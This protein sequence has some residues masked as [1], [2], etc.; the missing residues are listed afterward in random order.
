MSDTEVVSNYEVLLE[1]KNLNCN[2]LE[3]WCGQIYELKILKDGAYFC[4]FYLIQLQKVLT[5]KI[6]E[7]S[8]FA[9]GKEKGKV[10]IQ[11]YV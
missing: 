8:L 10:A 2:L 4:E 7:K 6:R 9:Y 5:V 1:Q 11:K 3:V